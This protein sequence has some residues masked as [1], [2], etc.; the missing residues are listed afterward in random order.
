MVG[1]RRVSPIAAVK[2]FAT[3][4]RPEPRRSRPCPLCGGTRLRPLW[5]C[6]GFAFA[7]CAGCG[8]VQ[9][10]PQPEPGAVAARYDSAYLDYEEQNQFAYRDLEL[11]ALRDLALD[12][13]AAPFLARRALKGAASFD[14]PRVLDVGCAT[15]ALLVALRERGWEARGVELCAPA[16]A[17]GREH[18]G[19]PI[20]SGDLESAGFPDASFELVHASHLIEHVSDPGRFVAEA[21]RIMADDGLFVLTTP[22]VAGFQA[23]MLGSNWRSAIYDHLYLFSPRT[24]SA[25]L[26]EHGLAV[27]RIAT[28]GGWAQ[29]LKPAFL[30]TPLDRWAKRAGTGD[31]M[32]LL[33]RKTGGSV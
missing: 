33:A 15:G 19:L 23:R 29:G 8:L 30:K 31:V 24:L 12:E 11:L 25:L 13:A 1:R 22:N 18:F 4:Q 6:G 9:Q 27:V 10:D 16:A 32:A 3:R 21:C 20:H 28:W 26:A 17:Y 2:T 7:R 14:R 5:D